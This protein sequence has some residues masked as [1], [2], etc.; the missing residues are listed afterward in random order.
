MARTE[1]VFLALIAGLGILVTLV[2]HY[3]LYQDLEA[4]RWRL[5]VL[6]LTVK[7]T[8]GQPISLSQFAGQV[9]L[10][11]NIASRCGLTSS[12]YAGL[13]ELREKYEKRGLTILNFPCNQFGAQMPEADGQEMLEHLRQ[14]EANIGHIFAK[15]KVNG[16]SADPLYKLLTRQ[17]PAIE[18]NFVKF[19]IDR[20]GNIRGRYG[21]EKEPAFL[22]NDIERLLLEAK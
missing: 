18:W 22:A 10:V 6:S 4:M 9:L 14:K 5:K 21:A 16:R 12:Q 1:T 20:R 3:S 7:D 15:I 13:H 2:T 11:V 8:F 19:L 17:A